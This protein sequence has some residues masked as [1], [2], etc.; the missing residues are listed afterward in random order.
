[1]LMYIVGGIV[2]V[3][4]LTTFARSGS[5][6]RNFFT[7]AVAGLIGLMGSWGIGLLGLNLININLVSVLT[8]VVLGLPG[9]IGLML[10][11]LMIL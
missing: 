1:M 9:I 7:S 5:F 4:M 3:I 11:R 2:A 8:A 6:L 10:A